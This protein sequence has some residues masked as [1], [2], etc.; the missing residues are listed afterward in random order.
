V[1]AWNLAQLGS[2]LVGAELVEQEE[3]Q[4]ELEQYSLVGRLGCWP[5]LAGC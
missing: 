3:A 4:A 1:V 5:V 2:A